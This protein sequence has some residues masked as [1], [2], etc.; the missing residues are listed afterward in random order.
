MHSHQLQALITLVAQK[1]TTT[2]D[3]LSEQQLIDFI[4]GELKGRALSQ[5]QQHLRTCPH[6]YHDWQEA[7]NCMADAPHI[8]PP[9]IPKAPSWLDEWRGFFATKPVF[10][11]ASGFATLFAI[12]LLLPFFQQAGL[13]QQID[14]SYQQVQAASPVNDN[15]IASSPSI[16]GFSFADTTQ[17]NSDY[18]A[19][20]QGIR[21]GHEQLATANSQDTKI[22]YQ[23]GQWIML[24][25]QT[26]E[27]ETT[28]SE[29]FWQ[30]QLSILQ[31]FQQYLATDRIATSHLNQLETTL[32]QLPNSEQFDLYEK[33]YRQTR[34]ITQ[35]MR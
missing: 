23:L 12:A 32:K 9:P 27:L 33:L 20:Q 15:M 6:C 25:T 31:Q 1:P 35:E 29:Q 24:L 21:A 7:C 34:L 3:C 28:L 26:V 19:F 22:Y 30:Q 16:Q 8:E 13:Q 10:I 14:Q 18:Q 2:S 4:N 5:V 17:P 11:T